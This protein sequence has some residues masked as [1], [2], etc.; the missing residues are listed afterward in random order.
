MKSVWRI[1]FVRPPGVVSFKMVA[2]I[3]LG[4]DSPPLKRQGD[5]EFLPLD[6]ISANQ[7]VSEVRRIKTTFK[8]SDENDSLLF[9]KYISSESFP[10]FDNEAS[11]SEKA[12]DSRPDQPDEALKFRLMQMKD[13]KGKI[14][15]DGL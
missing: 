12:S 1:R 4:P 13:E 8:T 3:L 15:V 11:D 14:P 7:E 9:P 2:T 10:V 5:N 6:Q